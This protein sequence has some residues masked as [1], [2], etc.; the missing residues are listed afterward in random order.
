MK[1]WGIRTKKSF[2]KSYLKIAFGVFVIFCS[3]SLT[4]LF[5]TYIK[6]ILALLAMVLVV[7]VAVFAAYWVFSHFESKSEQ[8]NRQLLHFQVQRNESLIRIYK[9]DDLKGTEFEE[10]IC[11]LLQNQGYST[12]KTAVTGDFGVDVIAEKDGVKWAI[13]AKRYSKPVS[14]TAISDA[15]AGKLHYKCHKAMVVTTNVFTKDAKTFAESTECTLISKPELLEWILLYQTGKTNLDIAIEELEAEIAKQPS[16][17]RVI[18]YALGAALLPI[19]GVFI[20][21]AITLPKPLQPTAAQTEAP[22]EVEAMPFATATP[23]II[24]V[25]IEPPPLPPTTKNVVV[26]QVR[27]LT[28]S[29]N[30]RSGP[31]TK[32]AIVATQKQGTLLPVLGR[33][34][35]S[36]WYNVQLGD[37]QSGWVGSSVVSFL[38]QQAPVAATIPP[39]PTP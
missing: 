1:K 27:I 25:Q 34:E 32:F 35:D 21:G 14:R 36:Y 20:V 23:N 31:D 16:F 8:S 5:I 10:L 19:I 38:G 30:I 15:V 7:G 2:Q 39:L 28:F 9:L 24:Q 22:T 33:T 26:P 11:R 29:A 37:G 18:L 6:T 3:A 4:F 13:Q 12:K 17:E